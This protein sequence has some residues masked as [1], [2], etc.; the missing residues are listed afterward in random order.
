[1]SIREQILAPWAAA[2][3]F[4]AVTTLA[5][6]AAADILPEG[7]TYVPIEITLEGQEAFTDTSFVVLGCNSVDDGRHAVAVASPTEP[8]RCRIKMPPTVHAASAKEAADVRELVAKDVGWAEEGSKARAMLEKSPRCGEI[9]E[10]TLLE[11]SKK[12][13]SLAA[14]YKLT[15][16]SA[17]C[18]LAKVGDTREIAEA[19][20]APGPTES[21]SAAPPQPAAPTTPAPTP[22]KSGCAG[23]TTSPARAPAGALGLAALGLAALAARRARRR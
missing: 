10:R 21:A 3:A 11:T 12:V 8:V 6:P 14:R 23:C 4:L 16:T 7:M 5:A 2:S 13:K 18:S 19:E 9:T 1:M 15:K 22:T 20:T 17:G